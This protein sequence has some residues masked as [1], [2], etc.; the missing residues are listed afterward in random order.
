MKNK[1]VI[2]ISVYSRPFAVKSFICLN[3]VFYSVILCLIFVI[4]APFRGFFFFLICENLRNLRIK[5]FVSFCLC[6]YKQK[7]Q[8]EPNFKI[9]KNDISHVIRKEYMKNDNFSPRK[10]EPDRSQ[11]LQ[12]LQKNNLHRNLRNTRP[13]LLPKTSETKKMKTYL[14]KHS[15]GIKCP[16]KTVKAN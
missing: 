6:G 12:I 15:A 7:M 3:P 4:F 5:N 1:Y 9:S 13:K 2:D 8:N 11:L 16:S 14:N 10:N